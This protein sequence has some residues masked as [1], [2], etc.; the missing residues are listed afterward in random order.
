M[1][2]RHYEFD[3]SHPFTTNFLLCYFWVYRGT[4]RTKAH[5]YVYFLLFELI[6]LLLIVEATTALV[7]HVGVSLIVARVCVG[8]IIGCINFLLNTFL[9]FKLL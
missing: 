9:N 5:G 7:V 6:T 2:Y 8:I 3:M 4:S 1:H